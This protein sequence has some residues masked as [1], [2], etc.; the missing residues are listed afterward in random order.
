MNPTQA[1]IVEKLDEKYL[2]ALQ[3]VTLIMEDP[4][5]DPEHADKVL[6]RAIM[7]RRAKEEVE[8]MDLP[9]G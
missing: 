7:L 9:N 2:A 6:D 1:L 5:F 4:Y 8:D 3:E